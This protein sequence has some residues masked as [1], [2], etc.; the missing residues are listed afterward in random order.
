MNLESHTT[1]QKRIYDPPRLR[2]I[3]LA[4]DE[5]LATGCKESESATASN[6][7][8]TFCGIANSCHD[9]GEYGS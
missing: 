2:T 8:G 3:E 1:T 4:T 5:V 6:M 9:A 7:G